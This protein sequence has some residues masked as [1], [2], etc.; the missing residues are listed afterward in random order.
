MRSERPEP[1]RCAL[2]PAAEARRKPVIV[3]VAVR[4]VQIDFYPRSVSCGGNEAVMGI[5]RQRENKA[6]KASAKN[7]RKHHREFPAHHQPK[8]S[9]ALQ[10][11]SAVLLIKRLRLD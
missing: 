2:L 8:Y 1:R 10:R 4:L 9:L 11:N 7:I 3:L 6:G 5:S